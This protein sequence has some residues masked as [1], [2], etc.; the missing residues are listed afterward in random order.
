MREENRIARVQRDDLRRDP[1]P[2]TR[3]DQTSAQRR[4]CLAWR[5]YFATSIARDSRIT[6]TFT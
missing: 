6:I 2:A 4:G 3:C 5:T 1:L